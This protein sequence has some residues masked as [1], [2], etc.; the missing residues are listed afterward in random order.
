MALLLC[1]TLWG[2]GLND[3]R[4]R[5]SDLGAE[6]LAAGKRSFFLRSIMIYLFKPPVVRNTGERGTRKRNNLKREG[7]GG[8]P[9]PHCVCTSGLCSHALYETY[10]P[11][12]Y[13]KAEPAAGMVWVRVA[14]PPCALL[15]LVGCGNRGV[16]PPVWKKMS[17]KQLLF[18]H[19]HFPIP[20]HEDLVFQLSV[21]KTPAILILLFR[22]KPT[23]R[24]SH[25]TA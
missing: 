10:L 24:P 11:S 9:K 7:K 1:K 13:P 20:A 17:K 19:F 18:Y 21:R 2:F 23:P 3:T 5:H 4:F 8:N 14:S 6:L 16:N 22:I 12:F 15:G 25:L